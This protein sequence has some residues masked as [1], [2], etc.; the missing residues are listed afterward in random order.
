MNLDVLNQYLLVLIGLFAV[1]L[2]VVMAFTGF[3]DLISRMP[4]PKK[5]RKRAAVV[6][7]PRFR[8]EPRH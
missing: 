4:K 1:I 2:Y 6:R 3:S 5:S 7:G 8:K